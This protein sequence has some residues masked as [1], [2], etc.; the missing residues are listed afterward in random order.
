MSRGKSWYECNI[1]IQ[2]I[3]FRKAYAWFSFS[4]LWDVWS[5]AKWKQ[6]TT[7][8]LENKKWKRERRAWQQASEPILAF[9]SAGGLETVHNALKWPAS[10]RNASLRKWAWAE[11]RTRSALPYRP[12]CTIWLPSSLC[13]TQVSNITTGTTENIGLYNVKLFCLVK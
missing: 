3:S 5:F 7:L 12:F 13:I 2:L 4:S 9:C 10:L 11:G 1:V 6:S 8:T